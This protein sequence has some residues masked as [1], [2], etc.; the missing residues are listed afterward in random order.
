MSA[1]V[2]G[3]LDWIVMKALE[4][5][6]ARRYETASKFAE[7]VQH[8]LNDEAVAAC[9]P[10]AA[11]RF[12]KFVQ[13]EQNRAGHQR[14]PGGGAGARHGRQCLAGNPRHTS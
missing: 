13:A 8:Y 14:G 7:D 4:K 5:D 11:Y 3:E 12:R 6:R 9:P 10:S 1:L 2:R